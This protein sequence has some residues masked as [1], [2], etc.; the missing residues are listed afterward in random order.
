MAR[1]LSAIVILTVIDGARADGPAGIPEDVRRV[2]AS[3]CLDCHTGD[4]AE[5]G[6]RLDIG[7]IHWNMPAELDLWRRV[8]HVVEDRRMPP[9]DAE[10]TRPNVTRSSRFSTHRS[11]PIR[12]LVARSRGG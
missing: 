1:L 11:S 5:A 6:V 7:S 2:L 9:P 8:V 10:P 3:R 4:S 12:R